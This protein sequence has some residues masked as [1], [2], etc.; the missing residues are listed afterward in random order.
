MRRVKTNYFLPQLHTQQEKDPHTCTYCGRS[1]TD[2]RRLDPVTV[3]NSAAYAAAKIDCLET[4]LSNAREQQQSAKDE[5]ET[6]RKYTTSALFPHTSYESIKLDR[7]VSNTPQQ[8]SPSTTVYSDSH[9]RVL[10]V[11]AKNISEPSTSELPYF[12]S[13]LRDALNYISGITGK[14]YF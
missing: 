13:S 3:G 12:T 5:L 4:Q 10:R 7:L 9:Y 14:D 11:Q 8:T 1:I 6:L 2:C